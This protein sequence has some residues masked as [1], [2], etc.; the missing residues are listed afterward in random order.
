MKYYAVKTGYKTGVFESWDE[1]QTATKGFPN[2]VFNSFA[3]KEEAEAFLQGK[4]LWEDIIK[5]DNAK[6]FL[7]SFVDG[8]YNKDLNRYS[9]GVVLARIIHGYP[10]LRMKMDM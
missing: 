5:E 1:C 6:G 3:T 4:D 10:E 8:S 9:Y 7:V 2:A